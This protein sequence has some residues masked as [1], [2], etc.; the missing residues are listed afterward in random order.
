MPGW[1]KT[2]LIAVIAFIIGY[3]AYPHFNKQNYSSSPEFQELFKQFLDIEGR[4]YADAK[5]AEEKLR[6]ADRMY[7]RMMVLF[8]AELGLQGQANRPVDIKIPSRPQRPPVVEV[9]QK[10]V[11]V[12]SA[13]KVEREPPPISYQ[14]ATGT[15]HFTTLQNNNNSPY[16]GFTHPMIMKLQGKFEGSLKE[17]G[18]VEVR[19]VKLEVNVEPGIM[20]FKVFDTDNVR[21]ETLSITKSSDLSFRLVPDEENLVMLTLKNRNIILNLRGL[22]NLTG[23]LLN[24]NQVIGE[25]ILVKGN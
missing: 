16:L 10:P 1:T 14:L 17:D 11:R 18:Q 5:T 13:A 25:L 9:M 15:L 6:L 12:E 22:P 23:K 20:S 21:D 8:L 24:S 4:N 7:E 3:L 2:L 19:R